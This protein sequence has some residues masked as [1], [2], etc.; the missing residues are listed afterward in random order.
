MNSITLPVAKPLMAEMLRR[1]FVPYDWNAT[2]DEAIGQSTGKQRA[3]VQ[4]Y[5]DDD[6]ADVP[7]SLDTIISELGKQ[8]YNFKKINPETMPVLFSYFN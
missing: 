5:N 6:A 7:E 2:G 1:G 3:F 4:L 8:G